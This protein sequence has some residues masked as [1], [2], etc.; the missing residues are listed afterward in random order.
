MCVHD[1]LS[2]MSLVFGDA[3]LSFS[4]DHLPHSELVCVPMTRAMAQGGVV[5]K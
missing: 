5:A 3:F 1:H 4:R 2:I